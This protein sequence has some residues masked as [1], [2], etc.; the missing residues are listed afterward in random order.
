[1]IFVL[2]SLWL[3]TN[4]KLYRTCLPLLLT[5]ACQALLLIISWTLSTKVFVGIFVSDLWG[6]FGLVMLNCFSC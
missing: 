4:R 1:M 2:W 6:V 3:E 5:I